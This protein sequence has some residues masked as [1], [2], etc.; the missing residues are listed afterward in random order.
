MTDGLILYEY[1]WSDAP[2]QTMAAALFMN[3]K[4]IYFF[5][6]IGYTHTSALHCPYSETLLKQCSCDVTS[7][8]GKYTF[9]CLHVCTIY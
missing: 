7:N 4:D 3:K 9:Y 5:N 2:V 8:Y 6:Q 1:S